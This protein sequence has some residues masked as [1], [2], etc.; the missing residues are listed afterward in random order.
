MLLLHSCG[1]GREKTSASGCGCALYADCCSRL[2]KGTARFVGDLPCTQE[3]KCDVGDLH[4]IN[5]MVPASCWL[6]GDKF[7]RNTTVDEIFRAARRTR[8]ELRHTIST[9]RKVRTSVAPRTAVSTA[10]GVA[11]CA[12]IFW[13]PPLV[14]FS[15]FAITRR[16]RWTISIQRFHQSTGSARNGSCAA[17]RR[18]R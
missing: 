3:N 10:V 8:P 7:D 4:L 18:V 2:R 6:L 5:P 13:S 14:A 15:P 9:I 1:K 12:D 16:K 11:P 17:F